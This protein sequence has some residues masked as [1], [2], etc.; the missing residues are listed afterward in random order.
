M[1]W[2]IACM[3]KLKVMN[4]TIGFRPAM[5]RADAEA[6]EAMFGDRRI[7]DAPGAEFLQQALRDLIGALIFG[8]FLAHDEDVRIA[9]HLF[10]HGVAQ[11]FA[12]GHRD[13]LGAGRN[14]GSGCDGSRRRAATAAWRERRRL[15]A[16]AAAAA[17]F[18]GLAAGAPERVA[19]ARQRPRLRRAITAIGV[20]TAT[21]SVPSGTRILAERALVDG[22]D[23]HG[24]LVG[25]D[26]GDDVAGLDRVAFLLQPFGE[27]ALLHRRRE[28]GHQNLIGMGL[29]VIFC[30]NAAA[31]RIDALTVDVGPKLGRIGLGIMGGEIGRLVDDGA[32]LGVDLLQI[33]LARPML[34]E[35]PRAHLLD[36]VMLVAHL[37]HLF[38]G[39]VFG[40][41]RH[42][43]AAIAIGL[44][45]EDDRAIA[46]AAPCERLGGRRA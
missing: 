29:L 7:D 17:R 44:H 15:A 8:D 33:V 41:V 30:R 9:A 11:S 42:G 28:R 19:S 13:H 2:S 40:R 35:Q 25:L 6:G 43:M 31:M 39:P 14:S 37:L 32:H 22:L 34:V 38:L 10:G 45:F 46:G 36:R 23:L 18:R 27:L 4:S 20:L 5:R 21:S 26:L 1:I 16:G 12:H 3:A 24:R